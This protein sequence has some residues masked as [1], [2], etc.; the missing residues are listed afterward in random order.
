MRNKLF[1]IIGILLL[2]SLIGTPF[3]MRTMQEKKADERFVATYSYHKDFWTIY[4]LI[5]ES[6]DIARKNKAHD[7]AYHSLAQSYYTLGAFDE[8]ENALQNALAIKPENDAYW[9]FLGKIQQGKKAYPAAAVAYEKALALNPTKK[10]H[11]QVL[12]WL[13]YF[14]FEGEQH[15]KAFDVLGRAVKRF[16]EDKDL[17]FDLTRYNLYD[18]N[19][20]EFLVYAPQYLALNPSDEN[21]KKDYKNYKK[22]FSSEKK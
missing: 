12:A 8:A 5:K 11:F 2:T 16:P 7:G 18:N 14:R 20:K 17:W 13:Y 21:I 22:I 15:K 3:V 4:P 9:F 6:R 1:I 10:E 19:I